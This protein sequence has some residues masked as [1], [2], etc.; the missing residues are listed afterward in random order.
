MTIQSEAPTGRASKELV[1]NPYV[2]VIFCGNDEILVKHGGRSRYSQVLSDDGQTGLLGRLLRAFAE[3]TTLAAAHE[4]AV[5]DDAEHSSAVELVEYLLDRQILIEPETYL[6]HTYLNLQF[7]ASAGAVTKCSFGVI[8]AG[9]LGA[10][11]A[12]ELGRMR[13]KSV[14]VLDDRSV[15]RADLES[16]EWALSEDDVGRTYP[17][18]LEAS[19]GD[20][21]ANFSSTVAAADDEVAVTDFFAAHDLV[22]VALEAYSPSVLHAANAAALA[23]EKPWLS[24]FSDGSQ[25]FIGPVYVPGE[26]PC[27]AEFEIQ[28]ESTLALRDDYLVYKEAIVNQ[29]WRPGAHLITPYLSM[30]SGWASVALLN[31]VTGAKPF[32]LGRCV[33]LDFERLSVDYADV[34]KLPRCPACLQHETGYPR[35]LFL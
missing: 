27:Y 12:A 2:R 21:V 11:I 30:M 8:G 31:F 13:A 15:A 7:G 5:F 28:Q 6:P 34:L 16:F 10:R 23:M 20:R 14:S 9:P 26:S 3:P 17:E 25:A 18:L 4:H 29:G 19:L 35:N 1:T 32:A 33:W 22:V 24:V